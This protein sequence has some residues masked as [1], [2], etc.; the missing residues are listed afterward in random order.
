LLEG[1]NSDLEAE[2]SLRGFEVPLVAWRTG[3]FITA[4]PDFGNGAEGVLRNAVVPLM[5]TGKRQRAIVQNG[6]EGQEND[7][8]APGCWWGT[9]TGAGE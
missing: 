1:G 5:L 3:Q 2:R 4:D 8:E 7:P 9:G 6:I